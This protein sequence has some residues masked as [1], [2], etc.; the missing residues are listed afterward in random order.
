MVPENRT[1]SCGT[2]PMVDRHEVVVRSRISISLVSN[3]DRCYG[4]RHT[5]SIEGNTT[6][7]RLE[8]KLRSKCFPC[9]IGDLRRRI[10]EAK[11]EHCSFRSHF[12]LYDTSNKLEN[13]HPRE[14]KT[15][16]RA[17][18]SPGLISRSNPFKTWTSLRFG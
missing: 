15:Y 9:L 14:L 8:Y 3:C 13:N 17:T 10:V 1:G 6:H 12:S 11:P 5:F 16:T 4:G 7:I 18:L 2:N